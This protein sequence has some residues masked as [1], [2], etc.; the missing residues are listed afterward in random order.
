MKS[1]I[2]ELASQMVEVRHH[3]HRNPELSFKEYETCA[4]IS[5]ILD[6]YG[7]SYIKVAGT[8]ILAVIEGNSEGSDTLVRADI[9]ALPIH[10]ESGCEYSSVNSAMHACGHDIH[11]SVLLGLLIHLVKNKDIFSGRVLGF[12]EPGEEQSPGGASLLLAEGVLERYNIKAAYALHTAH[13]IEVGRFGVRKG[14][15][16]ASTSEMHIKV[17]GSGG[18]AAL[19]AGMTNPILI[20]SQFILSLKELEKIYNNVIIAV[21]RV[22]AEGSTNIIPTEVTMAGTVRAMTSVGKAELKN[23]IIELAQSLG[24]IEVTFSDGYPPIYNNEVLADRAIAILR[25]KFGNENIV[26][27]G[28]RMTADDFGFFSELYPSFYYR[29]GVKGYWQDAY[30]PHTPK[31]RADDRSIYFGI[32]SLLALI[33]KESLGE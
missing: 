4:Y 9:D 31:F 32:K 8:G 6:S 5:R 1:N 3:L 15:Y 12:F 28:L 2:E 23:K 30:A 19:P 17:H 26:E 33:M 10:E 16:M 7:I 14:E 22:H 29:L 27:L 13:D 20:G 21:G 25:E 18:H 24:D 11:T